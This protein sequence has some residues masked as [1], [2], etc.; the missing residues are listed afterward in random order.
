[1]D[2]NLD[3]QFFSHSLHRAMML[4]MAEKMHAKASFESVN[5]YCCPNIMRYFIPQSAPGL[6]E[7]SAAIT[8]V[9][10]GIK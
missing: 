8:G 7:T 5:V 10:I 4:D 6:C 1:M 2:N 9:N 3:C